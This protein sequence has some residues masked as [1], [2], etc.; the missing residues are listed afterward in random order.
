MPD[1]TK[2]IASSE[3]PAAPRAK[4]DEAS[5][6]W[7]AMV[8]LFGFFAMLIAVTIVGLYRNSDYMK[9][10]TAIAAIFSGWIATVL[11]YFFGEQALAKE[12]VAGE[13]ALSS[14]RQ[15]AR[16]GLRKIKEL[17]TSV[18]EEVRKK[19]EILNV[20]MQDLLDRKASALKQTGTV[21]SDSRVGEA[22]KLALLQGF[23]KIPIVER[24]T[25]KLLGVVRKSELLDYLYAMPDAGGSGAPKGAGAMP[26]LSNI[27][28]V[29]EVMARWEKPDTIRSNLPPI[30]DASMLD[31]M[32][33]QPRSTADLVKV[34]AGSTIPALIQQWATAKDDF[35]LLVDSEKDPKFLGLLSRWDVIRHYTDSLQGK[36]G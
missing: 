29:R 28:G 11:A 18:Q 9:D 13:Q 1:Q 23:G 15:K 3:S 12:K 16:E 22:V 31:Y 14:E 33:A 10:V 26:V 19:R 36:T 5:A 27:A 6:F 21:Y 25:D 32:K 4:A 35:A 8:I 30:L 7:I 20:S 17:E 2:P 24:G 34:V